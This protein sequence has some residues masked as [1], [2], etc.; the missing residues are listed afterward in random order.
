VGGLEGGGDRGDVGQRG[1]QT[2][3][4]VLVADAQPGHDLVRSRA[5]RL[6]VLAGAF[7]E[8]LGEGPRGREAVFVE[9]SLQPLMEG[10]AHPRLADAP[11]RKQAGVSRAEDVSDPE[12]LCGGAGDLAGRAAERD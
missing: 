5:L 1:R 4:A 3:V 10:D 6:Q 11:G 7:S 2:G 8:A 9:V 12:R